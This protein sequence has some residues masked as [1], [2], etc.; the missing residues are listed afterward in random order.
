MAAAVVGAVL[1]FVALLGARSGKRWS[2]WL[3][4][5]SIA[6]P[7]LV[8]LYSVIDIETMYVAAQENADPPSR[9]IMAETAARERPW[10]I[11]AAIVGTTPP[12]IG[13]GVAWLRLISARRRHRTAEDITVADGPG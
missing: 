7:T 2:A 5:T 6:I 10:T 1:A 3:L 4:V 11:L 12:L 9:A 13:G 8:G